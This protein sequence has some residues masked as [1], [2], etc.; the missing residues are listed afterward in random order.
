MTWVLLKTA[1]HMAMLQ[2]ER[3]LLESMG[4]EVRVKNEFLSGAAGDVSPFDAWP[5]LWISSADHKRAQSLLTM[6]DDSSECWTCHCGEQNEANFEH[7]WRCSSI[8]EY[9]PQTDSVD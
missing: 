5:E 8:R 4:I 3:D 6:P 7:C 1:P 9:D 2:L